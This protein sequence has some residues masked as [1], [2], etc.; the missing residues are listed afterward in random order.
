[1]AENPDIGRGFHGIWR[2]VIDDDEL[3]IIVFQ[4]LKAFCK[5]TVSVIGGDNDT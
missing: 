5:R 1:M 3:G 4:R 2:T